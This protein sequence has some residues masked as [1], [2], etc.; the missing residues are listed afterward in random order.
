MISITQE[1]EASPHP[2]LKIWNLKQDDK[3]TGSPRLLASGRVAY[4]SRSHPV[5]TFAITPTLSLIAVGM[6][7]GTVL[8]L[9]Q[10][11]QYLRAVT[12]TSGPATIPKPKLVHATPGQPV[13]GLGFKLET[14][15][16]D[17]K[18]TITS[19]VST[20]R[21]HGTQRNGGAADT[22]PDANAAAVRS[23][24]LYIV[25]T[26]QILLHRCT[27]TGKPLSSGSSTNTSSSSSSHANVLDEIGAALNCAAL[28]P[29]GSI[30]LAKDEAI[31]VY[32]PEGRAQSYFYQ[33]PKSAISTY[34]G[35]IV[36][37]SPPFTPTASSQSAT[38][39]NFV[40][41]QRSANLASAAGVNSSGPGSEPSSDIAKV[42]VFDP[43]NRFVSFTSAFPEGVREVFCEWGDIF[44]YTNDS[45]LSRLV[46][47]S[48]SDK[49]NMLYA[50]N[51][52]T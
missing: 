43:E 14:G 27:P 6:A 44:V 34:L 9:R 24:A 37:T 42:T 19:S 26:H 1:E 23:V 25:T 47:R 17:V 18:N 2:V 3:R 48:T 49:L 35:H 50:K 10:L 46:E 11:D 39:R 52:C 15:E 30:C 28:L 33:G 8:M 38:V 4:G 41:E 16:T 22:Q 51:L 12:A 20:A 31:F 40:R 45:R 29:D 32:T 21:D 5:S 7:D 36:I 13:T